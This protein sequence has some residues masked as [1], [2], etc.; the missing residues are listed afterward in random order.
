MQKQ[1]TFDESKR[2][3]CL[4]RLLTSDE[5]LF[6]LAITWFLLLLLV[7]SFWLL[8]TSKTPGDLAHESWFSVQV[9]V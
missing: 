6:D 7:L 2:S 8:N 5:F 1:W 4:P 9:K 3:L